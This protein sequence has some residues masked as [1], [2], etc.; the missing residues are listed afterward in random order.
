MITALLVQ[1][2]PPSVVTSIIAFGLYAGPSSSPA[3]D[4]YCRLGTMVI[5]RRPQPDGTLVTDMATFPVFGRTMLLRAASKG[6][7]VRDATGQVTH[8]ELWAGTMDM[9]SRSLRED[10]DKEGLSTYDLPS[11][12][13]DVLTGW[14][15]STW[16]KRHPVSLPREGFYSLGALE[17]L[18][19]Q[20]TAVTWRVPSPSPTRF[21]GLGGVARWAGPYDEYTK[22]SV[23]EGYF[24]FR[25]R[26]QW[27]RVHTVLVKGEKFMRADGQKDPE[28][29][30]AMAAFDASGCLVGYGARNLV[31]DDMDSLMWMGKTDFPHGLAPLDLEPRSTAPDPFERGCMMAHAM[32]LTLT[33]AEKAAYL[34]AF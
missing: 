24:S 33:P 21:V 34:Q 4:P 12:E 13:S 2:A 23:M 29:Y 28:Q 9:S 17:A 25:G 14:S 3:S 32:R 20:P 1:A 19:Y 8:M 11:E 15:Q 18:T 22:G 6:R 10:G 31:Q 16:D 7:I 30:G 26:T 5:V 27:L